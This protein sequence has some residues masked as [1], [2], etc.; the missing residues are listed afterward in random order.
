MS[1][2]K[3][4]EKPEINPQYITKLKWTVNSYLKFFLKLRIIK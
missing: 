2:G 1:A 3:R 4:I